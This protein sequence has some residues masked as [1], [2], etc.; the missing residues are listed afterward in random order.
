MVRV[1]VRHR[2]HHAVRARVPHALELDPR[3]GLDEF[4]VDEL[5]ILRPEAAVR[6][7][8]VPA[9]VAPVR[10]AKRADAQRLA[11]EDGRV[12]MR[13]RVRVKV[14]ARV[15]AGVRVR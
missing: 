12:R 1:R 15:R 6:G 4:F 8:R 13:V 11:L 9:L 7:L 5:Q 3:V 2:L 10:G 14:R